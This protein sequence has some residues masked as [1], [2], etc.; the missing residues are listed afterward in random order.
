MLLCAGID[1][2]MVDGFNNSYATTPDTFE[3]LAKHF[4]AGGEAER[5]TQGGCIEVA[6][7]ARDT[8]ACW[9]WPEGQGWTSCAAMLM[10]R[11]LNMF[12]KQHRIAIAVRRHR[13]L[14]H[15]TLG[16]QTLTTA[17]QGWYQ[18]RVRD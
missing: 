4:M 3:D 18:R 9:R 10:M 16:R 5:S 17:A 2:A 6:V 14:L 13:S 12:T 1:E 7:H 8:L 11:G 15:L